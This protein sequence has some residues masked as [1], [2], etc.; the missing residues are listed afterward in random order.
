[1]EIIKLRNTM[2]LPDCDLAIITL[3]KETERMTQHFTWLILM[4]SVGL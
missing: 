4:V 2:C 1:V 3:L